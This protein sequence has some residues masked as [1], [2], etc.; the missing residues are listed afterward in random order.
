M[1]LLNFPKN[2]FFEIINYIYLLEL[3][4]T[5]LLYI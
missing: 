1:D 4:I 2:F 5:N 3:F